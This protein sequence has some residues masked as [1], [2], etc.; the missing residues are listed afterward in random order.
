M[1][2]DFVAPLRSA[3]PLKQIPSAF[4]NLQREILSTIKHF[5]LARSTLVRA[6]RARARYMLVKWKKK[7]NCYLYMRYLE[8]EQLSGASNM[9]FIKLSR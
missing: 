6:I 5:A 3:F 9:R 7:I 8:I 4:Y 2:S 1:C